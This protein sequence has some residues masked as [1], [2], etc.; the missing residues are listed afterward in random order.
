MP[1]I[2]DL[3]MHDG[4]RHF[5]SLAETYDVQSPQWYRLRDHVARLCGAKLTGCTTDDVCEAWIDF[6]HEGQSLST[7][8]RN[9]EWWFFVADPGCPESVLTAVLDH[10]EVLLDPMTARARAAG[11]IAP[12]HTRVLVIEPDARAHHRDFE[13]LV[14]AEEYADD[15]RRETEDDRGAPLAIVFDAALKRL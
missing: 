8:N 1:R 3:R 10:F 11:P 7:N 15:V 5:G 4:S 2:Y 6:R 9:G 13:D 12:G 14:A